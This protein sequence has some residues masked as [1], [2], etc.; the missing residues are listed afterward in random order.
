VLCKP[1]MIIQESCTLN[2]NSWT[3]QIV[4]FVKTWN[5]NEKWWQ[6]EG[7]PECWT[8]ED[9]DNGVVKIEYEADADRGDVEFDDFEEEAASEGL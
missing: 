4:D 7:H 5:L 3:Y 1:E 2:E 9:P 6:W 8:S